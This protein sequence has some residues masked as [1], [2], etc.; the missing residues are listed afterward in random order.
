MRYGCSSDYLSDAT[1][2]ARSM[3]ASGNT[4]RMW[5]ANMTRLLSMLICSVILTGCGSPRVEVI[6]ADEYIRF[7]PAGVPFTP[8]VDSWSVPDATMLQIRNALS[9][10]RI[11]DE[12]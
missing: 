5:F 12:R 11:E 2:Q 7:T 3:N 1:G 9:R 8:A 4:T 10:S 6:P